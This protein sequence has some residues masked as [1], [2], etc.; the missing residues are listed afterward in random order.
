MLDKYAV[1]NKKT[2]EVFETPQV[3]NMLV[4]MVMIV[5]I[6]LEGLFLMLA[7][8]METGMMI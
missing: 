5:R 7:T 8:S 6:I 1:Q 4:S 2:A 3:I